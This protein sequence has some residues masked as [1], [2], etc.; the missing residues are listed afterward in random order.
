MNPMRLS[1]TILLT[2]LIFSS[3]NNLKES[4]KMDFETIQVSEL[5][6]AKPYKKPLSEFSTDFRYIRPESKPGSY[7]NLMGI[8]YIGS[9]IM[10]LSE[11]T[12]QQLYAFKPDGKFI[13]KIGEIGSGPN[14]YKFFSQVCVFP[15]I[16]EIHL[17]IKQQK[18]IMRYN[19]GL[20]LL[21]EI[22]IKS[23]PTALSVYQEKYYLC[24]YNDQDI[25]ETN[26]EDL[27]VCDPVSFKKI[28]VL[29]KRNDYE[30]SDQNVSLL[31]ETCYFFNKHDTLFYSK[32]IKGHVNIYKIYDNKVDQIFQLEFKPS[33]S[34]GFDSNYLFLTE[35]LFFG[36]YLLINIQ[37]EYQNYTGY[38]N[39]KTSKFES[40][41]IINDLDKGLNF[42]PM[43]C[44]EDGSFYS[45][46]LKINYFTE[47]W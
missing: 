3:C 7:F 15:S 37:K 12:T 5:I 39:L 43:G 21:G 18:R 22:K 19:F 24:G 4:G 29:W 30:P 10:I 9:Q 17:Y 42:Y 27:I 45:D 28:K 31:D 34:Q 36:D 41:V 20:E 26:G 23:S 14:E 33:S 1:Y 38:Y 16:N 8:H 46:Y 2:L 40:F 25:K 44:C 13:G 32:A 11:K 35:S 6:K 47:F